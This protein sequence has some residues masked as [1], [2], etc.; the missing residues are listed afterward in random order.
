MPE[1]SVVIPVYN[2]ASFLSETIDSVLCQTF[3]DFE[4]LL[5]DDGSTDNSMEI[6]R[7]YSDPRIKGISCP[8]HFVETVQ[9]GYNI[10]QGKYI[11]QLDHDDIM[12]PERLRVQYDYMETNPQIAA[13]GGW[14][15]CFGKNS[16]EMCPPLHHEQMILNMLIEGQILNPT[17]FVRRR[18]LTEHRI[19]HLPE[20]SF[21]DDVKFWFEIAK[22]GRLVNIP[23]ILTL[24]RTSDEQASRKILP[25]CAA[26]LGKIKLEVLE[27]LISCLTDEEQ[28]AVKV[29]HRLM[30]VLINLKK[31]DFFS[32]T[33]FFKLIHEIMSGLMNKGLLKI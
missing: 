25:G 26:I 13:C 19:S 9:H 10:A 20:Y 27:Y 17:G 18:F 3:R 4:L 29:K 11:A 24:Y 8:H 16:H 22:K 12:V 28:L 7:S 15:R 32:D 33:V 14:M 21:Y 1:I 30:P 5:L 6:I 31:R 2:A 23:Q